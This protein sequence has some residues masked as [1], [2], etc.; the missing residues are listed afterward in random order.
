MRDSQ[1]LFVEDRIDIVH[2]SRH[3]FLGQLLSGIV[4]H[5]VEMGPHHI[6]AE[7]PDSTAIE[8]VAKCDGFGLASRIVEAD[9][10][11]EVVEQVN[12]AELSGGFHIFGLG[13]FAAHG[14]NSLTACHEANFYLYEVNIF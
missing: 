5:C 1:P 3:F 14:V 9:A 6:E 12:A 11:D 10:V 4:H 13:A 7:Q 8:S 2:P